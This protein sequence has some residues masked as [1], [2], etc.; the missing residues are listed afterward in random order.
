MVGVIERSVGV[1]EGMAGS[2]YFIF[3]TILLSKK[4]AKN[5]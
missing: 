5:I 2:T 4:R 3:L 1:V